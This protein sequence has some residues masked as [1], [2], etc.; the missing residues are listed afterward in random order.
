MKCLWVEA[1]IC[2]FFVPIYMEKEIVSSLECWRTTRTNFEPF[3]PSGSAQVIHFT[4]RTKGGTYKS[5]QVAVSVA[6]RNDNQAGDRS[7]LSPGNGAEVDSKGAVEWE[8]PTRSRK[9]VL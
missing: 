6:A 3:E 1:T 2:A 5:A 8:S 4:I 7:P 9:E